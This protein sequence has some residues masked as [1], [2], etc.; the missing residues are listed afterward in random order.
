MPWYDPAAY[1]ERD[2]VGAVRNLPLWWE[3]LL[4]ASG[5]AWAS[6]FLA[7][8]RDALTP[9]AGRGEEPD[10]LQAIRR[11]A[12]RAARA[13]TEEW[14]EGP[15]RHL[16]ATSLR[17]L[18][19][20]G[21][22]KRAMGLTPARAEGE[23]RAINRSDGGVPKLPVDAAEVTPTGLSGDRQA[24]RKHHGR[25]YQALC[26]WSFETIAALRA[27]GHPIAPGSAGE[28]ITIAGIDWAQ[29]TSGTRLRIG[30]AIVEVSLPADPCSQNAQ[31]LSDGDISRLHHSAGPHASRMYASV[32]RPGAVRADDPVI[33]EPGTASTG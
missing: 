31:W 25:P 29:V 4:G 19:D 18:R 8:Q 33:L 10:D 13:L 23:V 2:A 3:S 16:L 21:E 17:L 26:L 27:E 22:A 11:Q 6:A 20:T 24:S 12:E 1:E 7:T 32:L 30:D 15:G 14:A 5:G 28:N 9:L